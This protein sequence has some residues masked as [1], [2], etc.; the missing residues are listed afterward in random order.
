MIIL[1]AS[2]LILRDTIL[3]EKIAI[4]PLMLAELYVI[5]WSFHNLFVISKAERENKCQSGIQDAV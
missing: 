4:F 3:W 1:E 2:I 5:Y